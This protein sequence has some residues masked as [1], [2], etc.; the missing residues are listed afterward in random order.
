[1]TTDLV[2][3]DYQWDHCGKCRCLLPLVN[4]LLTEAVSTGQNEVR[5]TI[6]ADAA[7]LLIS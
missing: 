4:A 3:T 7:L 6:H 5:F 1:M 2:I